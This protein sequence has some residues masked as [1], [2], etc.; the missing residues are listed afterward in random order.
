MP[1]QERLRLIKKAGFDATTVWWEDE[2][3][4]VTVRKQEIPQRIRDEGLILENI[5]VPFNNSDDMWSDSK[6]YRD[7]F[8]SRHLEWME[9]C[10]KYDIPLMV[11]HITDGDRPPAPNRYGIECMTRLVKAAEEIKVNLAVENTIRGD[12]V[13]YLLSEIES[14]YLGLCYDSSHSRLKNHNYLLEEFKERLFST[15]LSDND[16]IH[17]RHWLPGNGIIDWKKLC[18]SFPKDYR[19]YLTLETWP[20]DEE[21]RQGPEVFLKKAFKSIKQV[22]QLL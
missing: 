14:P 19:G 18:E 8:V 21:V 9:D 1:L 12:S 20:T 13:E 6:T 17:D 4:P 7:S 3:G 15:H 22:K 10:A 16:G 2:E 5:H 11:I